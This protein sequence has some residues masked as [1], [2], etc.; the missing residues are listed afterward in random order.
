MMMK[1]TKSGGNKRLWVFCELFFP[2]DVSTGY[3]LTNIATG[4]A[5]DFEVNVITGP[6]SRN[7]APVE[8]M[9]EDFHDGVYIY[10]CGG[11][12]FKK[13]SLPGRVL[14][15]VT[16]TAAMFWKGLKHLRRGDT[17]LVVTNPPLLPFAV[18]LLK[19]LKR[20][21]FV[22][23]MYDVYPE[24]LVA[25]RLV[26]ERSWM[27]RL[28]QRAN[29][30]LYN[31]AAR[32]VS[33]GRDMSA[34]IQPKLTHPERLRSIPNWA[35]LE[36]ISPQPRSESRW[37]AELCLNDKFVVLYAGTLGRTHGVETLVEAATRLR[38]HADI[39]FLVAGFGAKEEYIRNTIRT[40]QLNNISLHPF[41]RPRSEQG[42]TLAACDVSLIS[43]MPGMAGVSVPSRMYNV[44]AAGRPIIAVT[45][46]FS[47]LAQVVR[48]EEIGWVVSAGDSVGLA[49]A[50]LQARQNAAGLKA[51][52][53]R[54][55]SA[56]RRKYTREIALEGYREVFRE[57]M[58]VD[59]VKLLKAA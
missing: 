15:M 8:A 55:S 24:V 46:E 39:H 52:G 27:V 20:I 7:F 45:D 23:L 50:V 33:I 34:L 18:L 57:L 31:Q 11:T 29:R 54:A 19:W 42:E 51:M 3:H 48:E 37:L 25:S 6:A 21:S 17:V 59:K 43:F 36:C 4:L 2:E 40:S 28:W 38:E 41:S 53:E 12:K 16:R 10:R 1:H 49:K 47:E 44:M 5:K 35:E 26:T 56:A 13:D 58:G 22:L 30:L 14:N 32:V 9:E